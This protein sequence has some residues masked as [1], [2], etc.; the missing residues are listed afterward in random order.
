MLFHSLHF[1]VFFP[2]VY[3]LYLVLPH[4][5]QN[6]MLLV[7]SYVFYGAWD[8]RY[9]FLLIASTVVD[10]LCSNGIEATDDAKRRKHL[11]TISIVFNLSLLG[12]FKYYDFFSF[13]F[14]ELMENFGPRVLFRR[15]GSC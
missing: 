10:Y 13:N 6:R 12:V 11:V 14:K 5:A 4:K 1:A 7:A 3:V 8:W 15:P 2:V 9:L